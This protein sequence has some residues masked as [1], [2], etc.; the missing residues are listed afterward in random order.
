[1]YQDEKDKKKKEAKAAVASVLPFSKQIQSKAVPKT[2]IQQFDKK[3]NAMG[4]KRE[5]KTSPISEEEFND[6]PKPKQKKTYK[7][8]K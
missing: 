3:G 8:G 4:P 2:L 1:M 5:Y 6:M 7:Y